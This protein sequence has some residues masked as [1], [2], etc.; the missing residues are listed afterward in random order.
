MNH[1]VGTAPFYAEFRPGYPSELWDSLTRDANLNGTGRVLDLGSGPATATI[2]LAKRAGSVVAVDLDLEMVAE[3][4]RITAAAGCANVEWLCQAAELIS[5]PAGHF[6][7]I[8]IASAFHWMDRPLVASKCRSM[9]A[10]N[11]L[12][13]VL[14]NPTPLMQIRDGSAVGAAIGEVQDRWFGNDYYV[15]DTNKL[16]PPEVVLRESGFS[17]VEVS[18][19]AQTQEWTVPRFLGFLRSTSSRPDQRLGNAFPRFAAEM[20]Q[21]IRAVEPSGQ[22]SLDIPIQA[23]VARP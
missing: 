14:G 21:A 20:E 19:V 1:F 2:E 23:I 8:V 3:G 18:H 9:L 6:G 15:L 11:G 17:E 13:A 16:D 22:W 4:Q 12:L 5:F 10:A 7:L